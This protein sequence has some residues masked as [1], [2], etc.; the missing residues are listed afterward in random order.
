[1]VESISSLS[2]SLPASGIKYEIKTNFDK[3]KIKTKRRTCH[4]ARV[5]YERAPAAI[6][7]LRAIRTCFVFGRRW[8]EGERAGRTRKRSIPLGATTKFCYV[9][10]SWRQRESMITLEEE[11]SSNLQTISTD[12]RILRQPAPLH[13]WRYSSEMEFDEMMTQF[14]IE[15]AVHNNWAGT[16]LRSER[17]QSENVWWNH[18]RKCSATGYCDVDNDTNKL[19]CHD[20]DVN[21]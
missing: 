14:S 4:G 6:F 9:V 8:E 11:L 20:D 19:R 17:C 15:N 18:K 16:E 7:F 5:I 21:H 1:M 10:S 3:N 2:L 12:T 13:N